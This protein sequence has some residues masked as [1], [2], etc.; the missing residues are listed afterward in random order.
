MN[1]KKLITTFGSLALVG[2]IG[3]GAT[4]AYLSDKTNNVTNTFTVSNAIQIVLDEQEYDNPAKVRVDQ[5]D[6]EDVIPGLTYPKDPT[7]TVKIGD[8]GKVTPQYVF[9]AVDTSTDV[10]YTFDSS[11]WDDVTADVTPGEGIK[12][13]KYNDVVTIDTE[14]Y[15]DVDD[16]FSGYVE[17][18][19][20]QPLFTE[21]TIN[22]NVTEGSKV[23]ENI[24]IRAAAIQS[25]GFDSWEDAY[26]EIDDGLLA[27]N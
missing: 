25:D 10:S 8:D 5:N 27:F 3:V 1:K 12:V 21:V 14:D 24:V 18:I 16:A 9:M 6:Y 11:H 13:Y 2:A 26:A 15:N 17:G 20:L 4:L 22:E 7:V 19:Q 23:L